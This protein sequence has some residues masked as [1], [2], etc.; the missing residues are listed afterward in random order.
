VR[1]VVQKWDATGELGGT[2]FAPNTES[3][4]PPLITPRLGQRL[5]VDGQLTVSKWRRS[6]SSPGPC[7]AD[8]ALG[9]S[10]LP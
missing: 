2:K 4:Y 3:L 6:S 7:S 1:N 5:T 10:V 8:A 9:E